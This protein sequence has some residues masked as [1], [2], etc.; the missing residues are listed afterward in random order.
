M[1]RAVFRTAPFI[2]SAVALLVFFAPTRCI[3]L[4]TGEETVLSRGVN[5]ERLKRICYFAG[6][7][8]TGL[9]TAVSGPIGFVGLIVPHT[10][11][12]IVGPDHRLLIPS[13]FFL[14]GAFLVVCDTFARTILA[15]TEIPVG[16]VTAIIGGPF[17]VF[18]LKMPVIWLCGDVTRSP[19]SRAFL[20]V[21]W[22][23]LAAFRL[24]LKSELSRKQ[25]ESLEIRGTSGSFRSSAELLNFQREIRK[26]R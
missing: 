9:V 23:S 10:L 7:V 26:F 5:V 6:S 12:L 22:K 21:C 13:S 19:E 1:F 14:G 24:F 3:A 15:P 16:V 8:L 20:A 2:L 11:R 25:K 18:L 17:F 4:A